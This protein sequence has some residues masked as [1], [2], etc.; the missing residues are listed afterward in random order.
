MACG[1]AQFAGKHSMIER[2]IPRRFCR[3]HQHKFPRI[4][5]PVGP[6]PEPVSF[7]PSRL[8]T[9]ARRQSLKAPRH[10]LHAFV[11]GIEILI[12]RNQQRNKT[13]DHVAFSASVWWEEQPFDSTNDLV[14][15][16]CM[17]TSIWP[18]YGIRRFWFQSCR[19]GSLRSEWFDE[20]QRLCQGRRRIFHNESGLLASSA[21]ASPLP[22]AAVLRKRP[23]RSCRNLTKPGSA[24]ITRHP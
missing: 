5:V 9:N 17:F 19:L 4:F 20:V 12:W 14:A 2:C 24:G 11:R 7:Q 21:S 22:S 6:V 13:D 23:V 15:E 3:I 10:L 16:I 8:D 1:L 18:S